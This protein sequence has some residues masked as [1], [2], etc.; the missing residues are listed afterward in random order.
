MVL[1]LLLD[2]FSQQSPIQ[3]TNQPTH[4]Y[5]LAVDVEGG[6]VG[7]VAVRVLWWIVT[8]GRFEDMRNKIAR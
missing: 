6:A 4:A 2:P 5:L 3:P 7:A 1:L 8:G